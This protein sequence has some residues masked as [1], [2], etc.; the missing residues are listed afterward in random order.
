MDKITI[1]KEELYDYEQKFDNLETLSIIEFFTIIK[2]IEVKT[3]EL[4]YIVNDEIKNIGEKYYQIAKYF[5]PTNNEPLMIKYYKLAYKK[6]NSNSMYE[7][8]EYYKEIQN[9]PLMLEC[10]IKA[11]RLQNIKSFE[12]L[13]DYYWDRKKF[14]DSAKYYLDGINCD[15]TLLT[16]SKIT[17]RLGIY[18][19]TIKINHKLCVKYYELSVKE[20]N[21]TSMINLGLYYRNEKN[22]LL[23]KEYLLMALNNGN[24]EAANYLGLHYQNVE[25]DYNLMKIY[26]LAGIDIG[27]IDCINNLAFYYKNIEKDFELMKKFYERGSNNNNSPISMFELGHYYQY[28]EKDY[29]LMKYYYKMAIKYNNPEA[30]YHYAQYFKLLENKRKMKK[31]L[32]MASEL[33]HNQSICELLKISNIK[34]IKNELDENLNNTNNNKNIVFD[35]DSHLDLDLGSLNDDTN[36]N[37]NDNTNNDDNIND[38]DNKV[39]YQENVNINSNNDEYKNI[40]NQLNTINVKKWIESNLYFPDLITILSNYKK[41]LVKC[42]NKLSN[43]INELSNEYLELGKYFY[44]QKNYDMMKKYYQLSI[45]LNSNLYSI[46]SFGEYYQ[47]VEINPQ[48]MFEYY[49]IGLSNGSNIALDNIY[50]YYYNL[51]KNVNYGFNVFFNGKK[52]TNANLKLYEYLIKSKILNHLVNNKIKE[53]ENNYQQIKNY[54]KNKEFSLKHNICDKC[55]KCKKDN[56]NIILSQ[57]MENTLCFECYEFKYF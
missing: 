39:K 26:Y 51:E 32:L 37:D 13:G 22:Y 41:K 23:M 45:D 28:I 43:E 15:S 56:T 54:I 36:T 30:M 2:Q 38:N 24:M 21:T 48:K 11:L 5:N 27:N 18:Y 12:V 57:D 35:L 1:L 10:F 20:N 31:Y 6:L 8:G 49:N 50:D 16:N 29:K 3:N 19:E 25:I 46:I 4:N 52:I 53:I 33:N 42:E 17:L 47:Y 55:D 34:N 7:L 44:S 40:L 9:I 14:I